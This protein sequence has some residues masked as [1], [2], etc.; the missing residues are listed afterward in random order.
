MANPPVD[1][2]A[3]LGKNSLIPIGSVGAIL[4]IIVGFMN[5]LD[6]KFSTILVPVNLIKEKQINL[7]TD[8]KLFKQKMQGAW[9]IQDMRVWALEFEKANPGTSAPDPAKVFNIR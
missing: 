7:D 3:V 6:D 5:Y 8:F 1:K 9:T 4:L 2:N